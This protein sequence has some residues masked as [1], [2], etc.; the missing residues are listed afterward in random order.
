MPPAGSA[1]REPVV[2]QDEPADADHRA[3]SEREVLDRGKAA[4][5]AFAR[6]QYRSR[7]ITGGAPPW[8]ITM[9]RLSNSLSAIVIAAVTPR[10]RS[11]SG[12]VF[13]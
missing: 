10:A 5:Q 3:E 1:A 8:G 7:S 6:H 9:K 4:V 12:T 11:T 13:E 2:H